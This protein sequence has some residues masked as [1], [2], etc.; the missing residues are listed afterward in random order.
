MIELSFNIET[1]REI[2][3]WIWLEYFVALAVM[4]ALVIKSRHVGSSF[5]TVLVVTVVVWFMDSY[6]D[7]MLPIMN[8]EELVNQYRTLIR[9]AWYYGFALLAALMMAAIWKVH[10]A[11]TIPYSYLT[12]YILVVHAF[13][14]L[15]QITRCFERQSLSVEFV[16]AAVYQW[17]I[18]LI[19]ISCAALAVIF[20]LLAWYASY[21]NKPIRGVV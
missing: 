13:V 19:N 20:A 15:L 9:Y 8:N 5:V 14:V 4:F 17:S 18:V 7:F 21:N 3:D 12:R 16:G 10:V 11:F 2:D 6:R 1:L